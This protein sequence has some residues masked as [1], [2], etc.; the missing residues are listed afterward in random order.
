MKE[1]GGVAPLPSAGFL[2]FDSLR[3]LELGFALVGTNPLW[4]SAIRGHGT[5]WLSLG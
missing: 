3:P 4:K 2:D 1:E 5:V